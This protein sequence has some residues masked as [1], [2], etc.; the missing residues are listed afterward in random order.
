MS[1]KEKRQNCTIWGPSPPDKYLEYVH[2]TP[3]VNDWIALKNTD[4]TD[5]IL[6][7]D[8]KQ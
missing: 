5:S 7:A 2:Y 4:V 1:E 8:R 6:F 3:N